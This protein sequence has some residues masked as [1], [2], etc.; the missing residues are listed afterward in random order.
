MMDSEN[1]QCGSCALCCKI[2]DVPSLGKNAGDWCKHC[3]PGRA[4]GCCNIHDQPRAA[5]CGD[6]ECAWKARPD[7]FSDHWY[8]LRSRMIVT[9]DNIGWP[10]IKVTVDPSRQDSWRREPY[11][12]EMRSW[13]K[14][15]ACPVVI[16]SGAKRFVID[17]QGRVTEGAIG[18][19]VTRNG[20]LVRS[21]E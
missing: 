4:S 19:R 16:L 9:A 5:I 11:L 12:T 20:E 1:R 3:T 13:T 6:F 2:F 14:E 17:L 18:E 7:V 10:I 8:P 15:N 21:A